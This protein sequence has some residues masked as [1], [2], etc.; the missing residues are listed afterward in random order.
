MTG[1]RERLLKP[2]SRW[3]STAAGI[4]GII[5]AYEQ[6]STLQPVCLRRDS[7][8]SNLGWR[9]WPSLWRSQDW[10]VAAAQSKPQSPLPP[11]KRSPTCKISRSPPASVEA[12]Q[13]FLQ[14][15]VTTLH[16]TVTNNGKKTVRSLEVNLTFSD[17][18][19]KPV[20]QNKGLRD[21]RKHAASAAGRNTAF[22]RLLRSGAHRLEPGAA[23]DHPGARGP[24]G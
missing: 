10:P 14:H 15:T 20:Q 9:R 5:L 3:P 23:P 16:A 12:A 1:V 18:E 11:P 21:Q 22:P 2:D 19:G 24:R 13:N 6:E 7:S 17:I 8:P 4:R